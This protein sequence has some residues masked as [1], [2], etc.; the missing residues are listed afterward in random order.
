MDCT[1]QMGSET[2]AL[3]GRLCSEWVYYVSKTSGR[4]YLKLNFVVC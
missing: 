2:F 1:Y 3:V 4:I